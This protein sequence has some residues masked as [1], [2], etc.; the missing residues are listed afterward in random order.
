M[1]CQSTI[2]IKSSYTSQHNEGSISK[3]IFNKL[4]LGFKIKKKDECLK[5]ETRATTSFSFLIVMLFYRHVISFSTQF[6]NFVF[7]ICPV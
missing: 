5:T 7:F 4:K 2:Y 3:W 1:V 6:N